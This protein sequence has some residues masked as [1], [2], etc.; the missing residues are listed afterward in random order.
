MDS[1]STLATY[2]YSYDAAAQLTTETNADG[3]HTYTYDATGQLTGV[4]A[5]GGTCGATG[6]DESFSYELNGNRT[7]AGYSTGTGN[8]LTADGTHTYTYDDNGNTLQKTKTS[9][10]EKTD[11]V[12][13]YRN[14]RTQ[15]VVKDSGGTILKQL[16][17]T[18]DT[19]NRRIIQVVDPDGAGPQQTT[20]TKTIY[21]AMQPP[22]AAQIAAGAL[23]PVVDAVFESAAFAA[24]P[25]ADFDGSN[26]LVYGSEI[27]M[28][29][30][31]RDGNGTVAWY[32]TDHLGSV[33]DLVNTR[34]PERGP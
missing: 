22:T 24:N 31:R 20:T 12:W 8:R 18:R 28:I 17:Y 5:S 16:A 27:D 19:W 7:M 21:D 26:A 2:A 9:N 10:G 3:N 23:A 25:Y 34:G 11:F 33:R 6:C 4:D 29:L 1:P 32:L 13:D 30:A 14:R 15:I